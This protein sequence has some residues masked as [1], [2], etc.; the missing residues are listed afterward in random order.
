MLKRLGSSPGE[1][2]A[3]GQRISAKLPS[4]SPPEHRFS[5]RTARAGHAG[6][7]H[8]ASLVGVLGCGSMGCEVS[9]RSG[10]QR[11]AAPEWRLASD[12]IT[13]VLDNIYPPTL[14]WQ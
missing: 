12:E 6:H 11:T 4:R 7:R 3:V 8:S 2:A 10:T 9:N 14:C 13:A 5:Q 1:A